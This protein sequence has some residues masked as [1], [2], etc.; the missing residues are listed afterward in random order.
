MKIYTRTGDAGETGL[1]NGRRVAKDNLRV[2]AYGDVDELNAVLGL[3][4]S[5]ISDPEILKTLVEIQKDLFSLGAQLAD[6][7]FG[8]KK[9]SPKFSI[10]ENRITDL[11]HWIDRWEAKLAPLHSFILP[12]GSHAGAFLH[13]ARTVCRRAERDVVSLRQ[14][15]TLP[16]LLLTYL[17]RLSDVLFVLARYVNHN[18]NSPEIPW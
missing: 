17:N 18:A 6:P 14:Q 15:E 8:E 11:E 3:A 5:L 12:G 10:P 1:F 4:G 13:L 7:D 9:R 2:A 16:P